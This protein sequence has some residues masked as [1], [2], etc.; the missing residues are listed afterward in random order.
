MIRPLRRRHR[1]M[2]TALAVIIP[3]LYVAAL[4]ARRPAARM[5]ALPIRLNAHPGAVESRREQLPLQTA[6]NIQLVLLTTAGQRWIE[7]RVGEPLSHPDVL[8]YWSALGATTSETIPEE[9]VLLGVLSDLRDSSFE[10]PHDDRGELLLYSLPHEQIIARAS[11]P[12]A[13]LGGMSDG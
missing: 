5:D 10:I 2:L 6:T 9:A 11:L 7:L 8:V 12:E 1:F 3:T 4:A 13:D